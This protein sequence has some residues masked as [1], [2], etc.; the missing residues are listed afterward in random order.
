MRWPSLARGPAWLAR[1]L[2]RGTAAYVL[3]GDNLRLGL[4]G[5][6]GFSPEE[7]TIRQLTMSWG[8]TPIKIDRIDDNVT[9]V[10]KVLELA[11]SLGHLRTGDVVAVLGGSSATIGATDTLRMVRCP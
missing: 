8:A 7:R 4:N 5:D 10:H 9:T 3:D 1:L 11:K 6:L 2:L